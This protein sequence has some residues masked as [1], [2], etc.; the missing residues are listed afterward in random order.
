MSYTAAPS[1]KGTNVERLYLTNR[2]PARLAH[3]ASQMNA[4]FPRGLKPV[5]NDDNGP[6]AE[7][8][9]QLLSHLQNTLSDPDDLARAHTLV[10][11]LLDATANERDA[12]SEDEVSNNP[13]AMRKDPDPFLEG[14]PCCD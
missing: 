10:Q 1:P 12:G 9:D 7:V 3:D 4:G 6:V 13:E 11:Q 2:P 8:L 14:S 5:G